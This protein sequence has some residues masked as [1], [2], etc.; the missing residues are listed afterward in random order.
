VPASP[1]VL[2]SLYDAAIAGA[3]PG[4]ATARAIGSL[5]IPAD[6][7]IV[8]VAIG[9]AATPMAAAS[10]AVLLTSLHQIVGGLVVT[11]ESDRSPYPTVTALAGDHPIPG[12]QSFAAAARIGELSAGRRSADAAVVLVSGGAS[13]LIAAPLRGHTEA[14]LTALYQLL[15]ASGLDITAMNTVRKRFSRWG[16]GRLALALAP[17]ATH[18]LA[19]SDVPGD[20]LSTIG[21]GPCAPDASTAADVS[22]ILE[23]AGLTRHLSAAHREY[24]T[25]VVRG[26]AAETPKRQ[27]P[28]FAHVSSRVIATNRAALDGVAAAAM[29]RGMSVEI[30]DGALRG[31]AADAGE[32]IARKLIDAR[33][34]KNGSP[35][36][37]IWGGETTVSSAGTSSGVA[38]GGRCQELAL[39]AARILGRAGDSAAGIRLLAAGTDGRDGLTNA[40]GAVV[41]GTTWS[42]IS[43]AGGNPA[44]ALQH[45]ESNQAL[46][47]VNALIPRRHTG[48]NVMDVAIGVIE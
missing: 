31:S 30:I 20:D 7:R 11:P 4:A 15:L 26:V 29:A 19:I 47:V 14:D 43:D 12:R 48:T 34:R 33:S 24:L 35:K 8:L 2:L 23:S 10:A 5:N 18:C 25:S 42:A 28:A 1:E 40:A 32:S 36:C 21:S 3:D 37:V 6:R 38:G 41:D 27:H 39:A 22:A 46:G 44:S 13:S 16:A 17:A 45:H 9:K